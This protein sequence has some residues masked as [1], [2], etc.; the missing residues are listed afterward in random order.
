[1]TRTRAGVIGAGSWAVSAHI[2]ALAARDDVELVGVCRTDLARAQSI[3]DRFGF[4]MASTDY[5]DLLA[6]DLDAVI[7]ASPSALHH[8]QASAAL[9]S[10]AHVLCEKPMTIDPSEAWDLVRIAEEQQREVLIAFG[11]NYMPM[12][13]R[14]VALVRSV[15]IG[16]PE[17]LSIHMSSSTRALL[18][19]TGAYPDSS[20]DSVPQQ[21]TWTDPA[22]SGGGYGQAQLSHA[23]ALALALFPD[24]VEE[25]SGRFFGTGT[26]GVE[27][28]DAATLRFA[29]G[30]IGTLSGASAHAGAWGDRHDLQV[31]AVGSEGQ[32]MVDVLREVAWVYRPDSGEHRVEVSPGDGT[33]QPQGPANALIDV[34]RGLAPNPAPGR[35]GALTVEA[36]H[37]LYARGTQ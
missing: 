18:L 10:G 2:P 26:P 30:A 14:A 21:A 19:G 22:L 11:W 20:A 16:R 15:G 5:R 36:L 35:L 24:R 4:A 25:V 1:M 32:A 7:V 17:H 31:R 34:A 33:Y 8:E 27:L 9:L 6:L 13:E 29:S 28:H 37:L 23:L 12:I 3:R